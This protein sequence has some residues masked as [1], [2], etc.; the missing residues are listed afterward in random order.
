MSWLFLVSV[1]QGKGLVQQRVGSG[2]GVSWRKYSFVMG[3]FEI[4][5]EFLTVLATQRSNSPAPRGTWEQ[6]QR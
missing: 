2:Q 1:S 6:Q 3:Q 5:N 4:Q